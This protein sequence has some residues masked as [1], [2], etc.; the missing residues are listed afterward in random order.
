MVFRDPWALALT[1]EPMRSAVESGAFGRQLDELE[2]RPSQGGMLARALFCEMALDRARRR[3]GLAQ[4]AILAAGLDSFA[5]RSDPAAG[6]LRVYEVDHP[7]SQRAKRERLRELGGEPDG[8]EFAALDFE[9]E[10]LEEALA[11]SS[12]DPGRPAFFSWMGVSMYL[13]REAVRRTLASI[14]ACAT[15]GSRLV[16]DYPIPLERLAPEFREVARSK[17]ESLAEMG[18]PRISTYEPAELHAELAE[19]G[20]ERVDD[21]GP[22]EVD[23]RWFRGRRDGLRS[24]PESRIAHFRAAG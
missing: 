19:L 10:E 15:P 12:F 22:E 3:E 21:V 14:R 2:L 9:R 24:N 13:T 18:E 16:F 11:R 1:P 5:L 17:N 7:A 4:Y 6:P 20:F 8:V 23:T